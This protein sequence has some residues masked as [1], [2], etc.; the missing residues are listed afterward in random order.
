MCTGYNADFDG[1]QMWVAA[2]LTEEAM[3]E[4]INLM[5]AKADIINAKSFAEGTAALLQAATDLITVLGRVHD[6]YSKLDEAL[7]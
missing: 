5:S 2:L 6:Q 4:A 3:D 7:N 1:D